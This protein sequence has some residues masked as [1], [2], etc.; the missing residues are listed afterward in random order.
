MGRVSLI[1][2]A[3]FLIGGTGLMISSKTNVD[4]ADEA[5]SL[6]ASGT[7]AREAAVVGYNYAKQRIMTEDI[8]S[9]DVAT[10]TGK[11]SGGNYTLSIETGDLSE[12]GEEAYIIVRS[13]GA[14]VSGDQTANHEIYARFEVQR[15]ASGGNSRPPFMEYGMFVNGNINM[16]GNLTMKV[17]QG[18]EGHANTIPMAVSM[19]TAAATWKAS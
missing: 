2:I 17:V 10:Y 13:E 14:V 6:Y 7:L 8:L 5:L 11:T 1:I 3:V 16:N 18:Y 12:T 4:M 9:D 19:K 15:G